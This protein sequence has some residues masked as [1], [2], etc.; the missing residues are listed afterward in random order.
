MALLYGRAGRL[1]AQNGGSGPG[2]ATASTRSSARWRAWR[3]CSPSEKDAKLAQ[4]LGQLQPFIAV[5]RQECIAWANLYILGQPNT[6]LAAGASR[7]GGLPEGASSPL[8][9]SKTSSSE[10]HNY[11]PSRAAKLRC[12]NCGN[13]ARWP[14]VGTCVFPSSLRCARFRESRVFTLW[15]YSAPPHTTKLVTPQRTTRRGHVQSH[16][17]RPRDRA[18]LYLRP[19]PCVQ[20]SRC[21]WWQR[22]R[23]WQAAPAAATQAVEARVD[24]GQLIAAKLAP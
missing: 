18:S 4:K 21:R 7:P 24:G 14:S 1:I 5:F 12:K 17:R 11:L 8:R 19:I 22:L 6:F 15:A 2:S 3:P 20:R 13:T 16:S 23:Q 9:R 10:A